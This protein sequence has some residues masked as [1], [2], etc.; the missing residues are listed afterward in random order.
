[1]I[2]RRLKRWLWLWL[3]AILTAPDCSLAGTAGATERLAQPPLVVAVY[4][5][6]GAPS[7]TVA[8]AEVI[9]SRIF[10]QAGLEV[11]WVNCGLPNASE[12]ESNLCSL[13]VY[14]THLRMHI[15]RSPGTLTKSSMGVSYLSIDGTGCYSDVFLSPV[16]ALSEDHQ[17][18]VREVLG[19]VMAHEIG[20][21]LLGTN[22]HSP[23]GIMRA[24]WQPPELVQAGHGMLLF[25]HAQSQ[26]M[27]QKLTGAW[28]QEQGTAVKS[29]LRPTK[30][31]P[32]CAAPRLFSY[33][34]SPPCAQEPPAR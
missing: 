28:T 14:P 8:G 10:R 22:S 34:L 32:R 13:A 17:H 1:M 23:T 6:A 30:L 18:D 24:H 16:L 21:L 20:H 31:P 3:S 26:I 9:A 27:K 33:A 19:H 25:T 12:A 11:Q 7:S 4:N 5:D 29:P 2:T 15:L